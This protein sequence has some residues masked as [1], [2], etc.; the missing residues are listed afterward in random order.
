LQIS[1]PELATHQFLG[2]INEP[3]LWH[4]VIGLGGTPKA[5]DRKKT[6]ESAVK[7][8]ISYYRR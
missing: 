3:L 8:F 2:L 7:L 1:D 4:R 6:V 5:A